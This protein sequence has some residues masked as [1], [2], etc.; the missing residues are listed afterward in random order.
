MET[1]LA[2]E[3]DNQKIYK[4]HKRI[5]TLA[6]IFLGPAILH[7]FGCKSEP[8]ENLPEPYIVLPNHTC[9]L[10]PALVG[11][12]F[13]KQMYFVASEHVYRKGLI[14]KILLYCF[15]PIAK[16]KGSSDKLMVLNVLKQI[17]EK[18]N[19]CIFPE[20]ER[21]F[22]GRT[23]EISDAIGKLVKISGANLVTYK[24]SGGYFTNPRWGYGIRKGKMSGRVQKVYTKE[25]LSSMSP[26]QVT[27]IIR[28]DLF[29]NAYEVQGLQH[30]KFKGK[31]LAQGMECAFCVCPECKQIDVIKT[32]GNTISCKN[33]GPLSLYNE[34]GYYENIK[35]TFTF[36]TTEEWDSWQEDYFAQLSKESSIEKYFSDEVELYLFNSEHSD[37]SLGE[38]ILALNHNKLVFKSDNTNLELPVEKIPDMAMYGKKGLVFSDADNNHYELKSK[39]L[40]NVRKYIFV[41]KYLRKN[42]KD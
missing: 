12:S 22:N 18:K 6:R 23:G 35:Q 20:G 24:I 8:A 32:E 1:I 36:K 29:E 4:R 27:S 21:S 2:D 15:S 42:L 16:I 5:W 9:D 30:I 38:G 33:C 25:E 31:K 14:S 39:K 34:Y 26:E 41:W 37:S 10:D 28:N 7:Y 40:I 3:K 19:I 11:M 13:S 17:R